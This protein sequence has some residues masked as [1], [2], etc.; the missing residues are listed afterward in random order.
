M[1]LLLDTHVA[2]W[3]V[4][5]SEKLTAPVRAL[6]EDPMADVY[7]SVA[8]LWEIALKRGKYPGQLPDAGTA[9]R[10]FLDAGLKEWPLLGHVFP[11]LEALPPLHKDPFDR[12]LVATAFTEPM[13]LVTADK[14]V[15]RYDE[16]GTLVLMM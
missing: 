16:R 10:D 12:L 15:G 5:Q 11:Q 3:T 14:A 7:F 1:H 13:R 4:Y 9:R 8:S 6:L 2:L